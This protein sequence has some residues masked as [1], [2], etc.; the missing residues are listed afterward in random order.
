MKGM[1]VALTVFLQ[2]NPTLPS[3]SQIFIE[4]SVG[5]DFS[6]EDWVNITQTMGQ[7]QWFTIMLQSTSA[8]LYM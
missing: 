1:G 6:N 2:I 8:S 5:F 4:H 7:S 3:E